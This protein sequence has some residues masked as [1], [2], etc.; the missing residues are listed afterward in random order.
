MNNLFMGQVFALRFDVRSNRVKLFQLL[1]SFKKMLMH[2]PSIKKSLLKV[3]NSVLP[4][5]DI[6]DMCY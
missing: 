1:E 3:T 6:R 2:H 5:R 4:E